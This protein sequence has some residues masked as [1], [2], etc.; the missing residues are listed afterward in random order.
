MTVQAQSPHYWDR[1]ITLSEVIFYMMAKLRLLVVSSFN[2]LFS[3]SKHLH[4]SFP[5]FF[6]R[7]SG[8][9]LTFQCES[10]S[11]MP[12]VPPACPGILLL[13]A[14]MPGFFQLCFPETCS[15]LPSVCSP[16]TLWTYTSSPRYY[17]FLKE[18]L[19]FFSYFP[20]H[21][22]VSLTL[23]K[24]LVTPDQQFSKGCQHPP[25]LQGPWSFLLCHFHHPSLIEHCGHIPA[26]CHRVL[27]GILSC[28]FLDIFATFSDP[29]V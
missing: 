19:T 8:V 7:V 2:I 16:L 28:S 18:Q 21:R 5:S 9:S 14:H 11:P 20:H 26:A 12:L 23:G 1:T 10:L 22:P 29:Q 4:H 17:T 25:E 13:Q 15:N 6:D 27:P 3:S 24:L